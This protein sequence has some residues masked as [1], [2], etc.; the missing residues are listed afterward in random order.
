MSSGFEVGRRQVPCSRQVPPVAH[1]IRWRNQ[2]HL[3]FLYQKNHT[4]ASKNALLVFVKVGVGAVIELGAE[5]S[6]R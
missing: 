6:C 1:W 3:N 5:F 4:I 2:V